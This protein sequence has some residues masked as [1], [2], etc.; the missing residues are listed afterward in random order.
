MTLRDIMCNRTHYYCNSVKISQVVYCRQCKSIGCDLEVRLL[1]D[2]LTASEREKVEYLNLIVIGCKKSH[3]SI[4]FLI[5][6]LPNEASCGPLSYTILM[7]V[8]TCHLFFYCISTATPRLKLRQ[9]GKDSFEGVIVIDSSVKN[10]YCSESV[11]Y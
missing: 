1:S 11:L 7:C 3:I 4:P 6:F 5:P 8:F 9:I 2:A 10:C